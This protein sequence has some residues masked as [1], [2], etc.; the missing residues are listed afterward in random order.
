MVGDESSLLLHAAREKERSGEGGAGILR[1][2]GEGRSPTDKNE[3]N[4]ISRCAAR[5]KPATG[6]PGGNERGG[7]G[8]RGI[9]QVILVNSSRAFRR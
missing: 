5:E 4:P 8:F 1:P 7:D 6:G 3:G 2:K 9:T